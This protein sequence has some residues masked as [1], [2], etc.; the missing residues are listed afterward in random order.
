[1]TLKLLGRC[2]TVA[3]FLLQAGLATGQTSGAFSISNANVKLNY[4]AG[5]MPGAQRLKM[6]S[7]GDSVE[8]T[9]YSLIDAGWKIGFFTPSGPTPVEFL[10]S[11]DCAS[12]SFTHSKTPTSFTATWSN[13]SSSSVPSLQFDVTVWANI[14]SGDSV[15]EFR[16]DVHLDS[17]GFAIDS[18]E[19]PRVSFR[20]RAGNLSGVMA[21][22]YG[23]GELILDP[24]H[25]VDYFDTNFVHQHPSNDAAM[26]MYCYYEETESDPALLFW[27]T[28]DLDGHLKELRLQ[29]E[30]DVAGKEKL[31]IRY[32]HIP[33]G[34]H[35]TSVGDFAMPYPVVLGVLRGD[36]VDAASFYREWALGS[37]WASQGPMHTDAN[38]SPGCKTMQAFGYFTPSKCC[39]PAHP[40][41]DG[42]LVNE[43]W[44][45]GI[46]GGT[47]ILYRDLEEQR[48][49]L[50]LSHVGLHLAHW[51]NFS[52]ANHWGEW[53]PIPPAFLHALVPVANAGYPFDIY[54]NV[55][56]YS[57]PLAG[58]STVD[59]PYP[60]FPYSWGSPCST[61]TPDTTP[62]L[63]VALKNEGIQPYPDQTVEINARDI[64]NFASCPSDCDRAGRLM[65]NILFDLRSSVRSDA[66]GPVPFIADYYLNFARNIPNAS[67]YLDNFQ[68][69]HQRLAYTPGYP[70]GGGAS[71]MQAKRNI[72]D[73][74]RDEQRACNP[75]FFVYS[76][77]RQEM[78]LGR[79]EIVTVRNVVRGPKLVATGANARLNIPLFSSVYHENQLSVANYQ[80]SA[81][82]PPWSVDPASNAPTIA[83]MR[84]Q[85]QLLAASLQFGNF[86]GF[87]SNLDP[88]RTL[89]AFRLSHP[90]VDDFLDMYTAFMGVLRTDFTSGPPPATG[91]RPLSVFGERLRDPAVTVAGCET[92]Q[93][94]PAFGFRAFGL[95]DS[96][97]APLSS[98][99]FKWQ[100]YVYVTAFRR[101]DL[102]IG[103]RPVIGL[104]FLNWSLEADETPSAGVAPYPGAGDQSVACTID[105]VEYGMS[106]SYALYRVESD[107]SESL[108]GSVPSL[109]STLTLPPVAVN[110]S[111]VKFLLP[112]PQ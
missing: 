48:N 98:D 19:Y 25:Q 46:P 87:G 35:D 43:S 24:V 70:T 31:S 108:I 23:E 10:T 33:E 21:L 111:S 9:A 63:D 61:P 112:K 2:A 37:P 57:K 42:P 73:R 60:N 54:F 13:L 105:T 45:D 86:P 51:D 4:I 6:T 88:A 104:Q 102:G 20:E 80:I 22:P 99:R 93:E 8:P 50:G 15:V 56:L 95:P 101:A 62:L 75:D 14:A 79:V 38:F 100:P 1:M 91:A 72:L 28:R 17:P 84:L 47:S 16:L 44:G 65:D 71:W 68:G 27:G 5:G 36:W 53:L 110:A 94:V 90:P 89:A 3:G 52:F 7:I 96:K 92:D 26:Q 34:H 40:D 76:E 66:S 81:D 59:H 11:N 97:G 32:K 49:L 83:F 82:L 29:A 55:N 39:D 107:N 78:L 12:G 103:S 85:R 69:L 77:W 106:G 30:L 18:I 67:V 109:G 64:A 41:L 58:E 74:I